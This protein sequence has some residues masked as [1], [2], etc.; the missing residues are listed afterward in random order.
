MCVL[1]CVCS[2]DSERT[3]VCVC[4]ITPAVFPVVINVH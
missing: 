3:H 1:V 2:C 4:L